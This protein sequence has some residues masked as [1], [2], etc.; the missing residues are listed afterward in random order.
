VSCPGIG[1]WSLIF[2]GDADDDVFEAARAGLG[3]RGVIEFTVI[4]GVYQLLERLMW[5]CR[6]TAPLAAWTVAKTS[7]TITRFRRSRLCSTDRTTIRTVSQSADQTMKPSTST[8][9]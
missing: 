5:M 6:L 3:E 8:M 4:V 1:E 7:E 9:T 2:A